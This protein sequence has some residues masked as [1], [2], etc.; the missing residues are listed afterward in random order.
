MRKIVLFM[1]LSLAATS[2]FA[3]I[4]RLSKGSIS[5]IQGPILTKCEGSRFPGDEIQKITSILQVITINGRKIKLGVTETGYVL[6]YNPNPSIF[7]HCADAKLS[8]RKS[9]TELAFKLH[10]INQAD[11][12]IDYK[13][14]PKTCYKTVMD[15]VDTGDLETMDWQQSDVVIRCP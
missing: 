8:A 4:V 7:E 13:T 3:D 10:A 1:I 11:I 9:A 15:I 14:N 2:S 5:K 12:K 6:R